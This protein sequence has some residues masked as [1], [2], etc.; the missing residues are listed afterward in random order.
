MGEGKR[1]GHDPF[2]H[3]RSPVDNSGFQSELPY[4]VVLVALEED[5]DVLVLTNLLGPVDPNALD[6]GDPVTV[7]FE[8]RGEMVVP[9]FR[10]AGRNV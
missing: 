1:P 3:D 7:T 6:I 4:V 10:L 2:L 5:P 9:Q 8:A